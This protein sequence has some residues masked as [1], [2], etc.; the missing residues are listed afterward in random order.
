[1][2][3][4][5]QIFFLNP[6]GRSSASWPTLTWRKRRDRQRMNRTGKFFA[7][8]SV[9]KAL[10]CDTRLAFERRRDNR[11][12]KMALATVWRRSM[13]RMQMRLVDNLQLRRRQ[14]CSQF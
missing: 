4:P 3:K 6:A 5:M 11:H 7:Q 12:A 8:G 14:R 9:Y 1:M 10:A 13:T 2:T